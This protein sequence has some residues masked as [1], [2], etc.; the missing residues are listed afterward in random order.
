MGDDTT[1][2]LARS[3]ARY[4]ALV[5]GGL[6][7]VVALAI[8]VMGILLYLSFSLGSQ[9]ERLESVAAETHNALCALYQQ[10]VV[11][12]RESFPYRKTGLLDESGRVIISAELIERGIAQRESTIE[13]L[14]GSGLT[15]S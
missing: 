1:A 2:K 15:C 10:N 11:A 5:V 3:L 8:T 9:S 12:Q 4:Q 14:K 7:F 13:A 6:A